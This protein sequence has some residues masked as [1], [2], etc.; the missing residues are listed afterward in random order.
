MIEA[1]AAYEEFCHEADTAYEEVCQE[2]DELL[3]QVE[4]MKKDLKDA[5]GELLV[6]IPEPGS[7]TAKLLSANVLL[8]REN[9]K[10]RLEGID[11]QAREEQL[12]EAA[13]QRTRERDEARKNLAEAMHLWNGPETS[14]WFDG[15]RKE[16]AH[17]VARWGTKHDGGKNPEDWFWLL[18][19]LGGKALHSAKTGDA[20]K[21]LHHTIST[22]AALLN[23]H[24]HLLGLASQFRPGIEK[25]KD[26]ASE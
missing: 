21:A 15:V 3:K 8:R 26:G 11:L 9:E 5:A 17:Q 18:G 12:L 1:D 25:P 24:A 13:Q 4:Q 2:R 20:E 10:V 22:A 19:Y 14:E 16:A 6:D 23:W 7:T